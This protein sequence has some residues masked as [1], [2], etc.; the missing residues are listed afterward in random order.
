[1]LI[2]F[3]DHIKHIFSVFILVFENGDADNNLCA[4]N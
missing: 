3:V 4:D 2:I 1:M